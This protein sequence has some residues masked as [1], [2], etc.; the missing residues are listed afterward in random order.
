MIETLKIAF[1]IDSTYKINAFIY[2][3]KKLPF[4]GK[5]ISSLW[6]G[7]EE[8]KGVIRAL[9]ILLATLWEIIKKGIYVGL[10][11]YFP[12]TI[13]K[14]TG[15]FVHIFL[16]LSLLG[17]LINTVILAANSKKYYTVL[18]LHMDA[19]RYAL[20]S[21]AF[22]LLKTF[23][24]FIPAL[25]LFMSISKISLVW[26]I[27]MLAS[28]VFIKILGEAFILFYYDR[29]GVYLSN[30]FLFNIIL[31]I[32]FLGAGYIGSY[33][34]IYMPSYSVLF[35]LALFL[36]PLSPALTYLKR[37]RKYQSAYQKLL[38]PNKIIFDVEES[39]VKSRKQQVM[40]ADKDF[41]VDENVEKKKGFSYFNALF[42]A[43]HR[44]ILMRS[45]I[46]F[47]IGYALFFVFLLF[48]LFMNS[49]GKASL[50]RMLMTMLPYMVFI[51]YMTNR[52][53]VVTQAMFINCD[54]SML[55]YNFYREPKTLLGI[56]KTRLKTLVFINLIPAL[57]IAFALPILLYFSGGAPH[58]I[59]Y[60]GLFLSILFMS[61]F[62]S[63]HHLVLYYL[64][65]P[66]DIHLSQKSSMYN[67]LNSITYVLCYFCIRIKVDTTIFS[68]G[69]IVATTIY[70]LLALYLIYKKA[71]TTFKLK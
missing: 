71:P 23:L 28:M 65:Q 46:K 21:F 25:I 26:I 15:S 45:S 55:S 64:L 32:L 24:A 54:H 44:R 40:I 17:G 1:K 42:F 13:V 18:L 9:Y 48:L 37:Y 2:R 56:F 38:T 66:Y 47:A 8:I 70:I 35:F 31:S 43:R 53:A 14:E 58:F 19:K 51:M 39:T 68:I 11:I 59:T 49:A 4:I 3:I 41:E 27:P 7:Q 67:I 16:C 50:Q 10:M 61:I 30:T 60:I 33:F 6:Y 34:G 63:V 69:T 29:K 62:F 57:V 5:Y 52:G 12:L 36:L 20:S 22:Y